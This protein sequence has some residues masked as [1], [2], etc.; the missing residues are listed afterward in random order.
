MSETHLNMTPPTTSCTTMPSKPA[1]MSKML[2][3][4]TNN[5]E[6]MYNPTARKLE[7]GDMDSFLNSF[8]NTSIDLTPTNDG[9]GCPIC[10][11]VDP[12]GPKCEV[13]KVCNMCFY[14]SKTALT[15][16]GQS[17]GECGMW[18]GM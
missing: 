15:A 11:T 6:T 2:R 8:S 18:S 9:V 3:S 5:Q 13:C 7:F 12:H 17:E 16:F 1:K 14:P 4:V 10:C